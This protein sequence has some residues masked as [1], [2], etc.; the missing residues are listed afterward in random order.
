MEFS[1]QEYW[2]GLLFPPPEDLI[3]PGIEPVS[4]A[5]EVDSLPP[6][7]LMNHYYSIQM[8][9][10]KYCP[11]F[12]LLHV[13]R[14]FFHLSF[15]YL[16]SIS[17]TPPCHLSLCTLAEPIF[18][19]LWPPSLTDSSSSSGSTCVWLVL[20]LLLWVTWLSS[21]LL[22]GCA[23]CLCLMSWCL[24]NF[25]FFF[26]NVHTH[27]TTSFLFLYSFIFGCAGSSLLCTAFL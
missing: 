19:L 26:K 12:F 10:W 14:L 27:H 20:F 7:K 8:E 15:K 21:V 16:V 9:L 13:F 1:R 6:W 25:V 17:L 24:T 3:D 11:F 18:L 5:L 4:P 22:W 2:S 23:G